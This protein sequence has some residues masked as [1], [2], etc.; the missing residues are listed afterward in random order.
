M[1]LTKKNYL[2][3]LIAFCLLSLLFGGCTSQKKLV[4]DPTLSTGKKELTVAA[5]SDLTKAFTEVG[6]AF[7][8]TY[9]CTVTFSFGSTGNLSEQ[10]ANGAPFD[11]FAA[12]NESVINDLDTKGFIVSETRS[13]YGL[14]RI[15]IVT[16][17]DNTLEVTTME[18]LLK[19]EVKKIAMAKPAHAPYGLAAKQAIESSGLWEELEPKMIYGN[20]ISDTLT[21]LTT[22]NVDAAFIALSLKDDEVLNFNLLNANM[23][24]PLRQAMAVVKGS[25]EEVLARKFVE[26]I[27]SSDGQLIMSKY[28]FVS[29]EE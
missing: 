16:L 14:G 6:T 22:G 25:K 1:N 10:I 3:T 28:G 4:S 8:K 24:K 20:N 26:Y 11:V 12:A 2:T 17:K 29:P 19:P 21:L 5:A 7:E 13:L 18:D 15:G 27:N 9:N 23:H